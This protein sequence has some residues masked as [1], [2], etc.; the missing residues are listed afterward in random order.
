MKL[1]ITVEEWLVVLMQTD[2][3]FISYMQFKMLFANEKVMFRVATA[4]QEVHGLNCFS[5]QDLED[6]LAHSDKDLFVCFRD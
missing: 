6:T 2:L 4:L 3:N 5:K 1:P